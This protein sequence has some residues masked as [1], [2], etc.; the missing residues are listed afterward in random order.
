MLKCIIVNNSIPDA[1]VRKFLCVFV[2]DNV[3][4]LSDMSSG[5]QV[6]SNKMLLTL[7]CN[8]L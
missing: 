8:N 3:L 1:T 6:E 2:S 5:K 4:K 7:C